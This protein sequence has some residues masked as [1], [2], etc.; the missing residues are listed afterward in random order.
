LETQRL[1]DLGEP[2]KKKNCPSSFLS[3]C[4]LPHRPHLLGNNPFF[5][6]LFAIITIPT[7]QPSRK[8]SGLL[9]HFWKKSDRKTTKE[10]KAHVTNEKKG[11]RRGQ[12]VIME[13]MSVS[14]L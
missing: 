10:K 1:I 2:G 3:Y 5:S 9:R 7:S 4:R 12:S 13:K 14:N 11:T 8:A 6:Y